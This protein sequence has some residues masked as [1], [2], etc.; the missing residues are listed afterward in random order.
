MVLGSQL[1]TCCL[2]HAFASCNISSR[3][4]VRYHPLYAQVPII[5]PPSLANG[6]TTQL[7]SIYSLE[8]TMMH[9]EI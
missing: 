2:V 6:Q 1:W 3:T 8:A 5:V 4:F 9:T 7:K